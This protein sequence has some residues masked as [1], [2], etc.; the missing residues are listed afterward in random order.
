VEIRFPN[1][2]GIAGSVFTTGE[3]INIP[4]AYADLRFN[5]AFDKKTGFF[6][7]SILTAPVKNKTGKI[8]GVTQVLNKKRGEFTVADIS[9]LLAINTQISM[10]I[11]NAKLFDDVESI[12]NYNESI[13]ESMTNGVMTI[14]ENNKIV[15]CNTFGLKL[16]NLRVIT[17]IL[18][19]SVEQFFIGPNQWLYEKINLI[20]HAD[21][22][23]KIENIMD[24]ELSFPD[25]KISVNITIMPLFDNNKKHLGSMIMID[26][27]SDEKRMKST[28]S[29]YMSAELAEKLMQSTE[30]SL[31][32]NSSIATMLFTDLRNFTTLSE[33][34]GPEGTVTLLNEYF[35]LMVDCIQNEGGILDKFIGDA[36]MAVFGIPLIH[37][38]DPDRAVRSA[39]SMMKTLRVFNERRSHEK[40]I[41]IDHGIGINT[42]MIVSGNI[43]S[44]KRMDFTVIGDGV[45]LA[46]RIE[47]LCKQ[48]G[49]NVLISE[50]TFKK[51]KATYRS[52]VLDKVIVKGKNLPV[53]IYEII[54]FHDEQSFP[55]QIE[56]LNHFNNGI[57]Y[58]HQTKW[59]KAI[60]CFEQALKANMNDK[61]SQL[62]IQRCKQLK[63]SPP[64]PD[65]NGVWIFKH[66]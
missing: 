46:S 38:D 36:M 57:E 60:T 2:L 3:V 64:S 15:T 35:S 27:I 23:G 1:H 20:N 9:Q 19:K 44:E 17:D 61:P 24:V 33:S 62:Y 50:F 54:D 26:D 8:I 55:N 22:L 28:M 25:K 39:I 4:Y 51:L 29:R 31:G 41:L 49:A 45:N 30:F 21:N 56:V 63:K 59:D 52:R 32:G 43:G 7:R 37:E 14:N 66:K 42:D 48:Y 34:L 16:F 58:Y 11:E 47:S 65:W 6:T 53:S 5:P 12:K 13:L 18:N 40:L 10:A